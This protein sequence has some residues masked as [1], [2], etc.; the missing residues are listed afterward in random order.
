MEGIPFSAVGDESSSVHAFFVR[1]ALRQHPRSRV[2]F[3][4][5]PPPPPPTT[6]PPPF[7]SRRRA[8]HIPQPSVPRRRAYGTRVTTSYRVYRT[9][10]RTHTVVGYARTH[11]VHARRTDDT[12]VT[13]RDMNPVRH[14]HD[15][16]RP[17]WTSGPRVSAHIPRS[18]YRSVRTYHGYP[19]DFA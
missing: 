12:A 4:L 18:R 5:V 19:G 17:D 8:R 13:N 11:V 2:S 16:T 6:A 10:S 1:S 9:R 15:P 14:G 7:G 3:R